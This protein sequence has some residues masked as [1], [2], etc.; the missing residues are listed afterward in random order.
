MLGRFG[1]R[2]MWLLASKI[3][4]LPVIK[5]RISIKH[6]LLHMIHVKFPLPTLTMYFENKKKT[7]PGEIIMFLKKKGLQKGIP[8]KALAQEV[9]SEE[10]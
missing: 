2:C 1:I 5:L 6:M 3:Q 7:H 4:T 10:V 8:Y 9:Q